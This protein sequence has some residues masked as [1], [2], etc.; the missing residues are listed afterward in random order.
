[1]NND[2]NNQ[3]GFGENNMPNQNPMPSVD[4]TLN[5]FNSTTP[6]V[7][8]STNVFDDPMPSVDPTIN[9]FSQFNNN[10]NP[11]FN[12]VNDNVQPGFNPVNNFDNQMGSPVEPTP[13]QSFDNNP[14]QP[15][16][17]P[18]NNYNMGPTPT[19]ESQPSTPQMPTYQMYQAP[20][21][22]Y[23]EKPKKNHTGLVV[24]IVVLVLIALGVGGYFLVK[25]FLDRAND[26][27]I[28][29]LEKQ[30][31]ED[32]L[33]EELNKNYEVSTLEAYDGDLYVIVKNNNNVRVDGN[34]K[35]DFYDENGNVID[36]GTGLFRDLAPNGKSYTSIYVPLNAKK[37]Y[38]TYKVTVKLSAAKERTNYRDEIDLKVVESE[39]YFVVTVT[40]N[41][42]KKMDT[43]LGEILYFDE[44][45]KLV[46]SSLF[47]ISDLEGNGTA[48]G[49]SFVP[50]GEGLN[51][52]KYATYEAVVTSAYFYTE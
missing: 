15:G 38:K 41:T 17:N 50:Y 14:V 52:I 11:G 5:G 42:A 39:A 3:F 43:V 18:V 37:G 8:P 44:A 28:D 33:N 35:I 30:K 22:Q 6:S 48:T 25:S 19:V 47:S 7:N 1:M 36:M 45:G 40:N 12:P 46:D 26:P 31:E 10:V 29:L 20:T 21:P 32:K 27:Y 9:E 24:T 2:Y 34:I 13:V 4:P 51:R 23:E 49:K 16:F